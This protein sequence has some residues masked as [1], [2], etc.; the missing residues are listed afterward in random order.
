[1]E[2]LQV[3]ITGLG[4]GC[5]YGLIAL[6]FVLIYKA[7]EIVNFAQG[8]LLMMGAFFGVTYIGILGL[9]YWLGL[10]LTILSMAVFGYLLD[11]LIIRSMIGE[12][13]FSVII[14]TISIGF[15]L[16]SV[17]GAFWGNDILSLETPYSGKMAD[18]AGLVIAQDY[19]VVIAGT[20][21]LSLA[22]FLFFRFSSLGVAMQA[23][24]QNQLAAYYMGIPVK[25][26]FSL[27][28]AV[29]AMVASVAGVLM[30]PISLVSPSMGFIGIKA[31]AAAVIGGFGSLPGALLGGL[32]IGG[33]E[34]LAGT[35]LPLGFQEI[36]AYLIMFLVLTIRPQ[37]LFAQ[38]QQ[39]K[40]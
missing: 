35:Y 7:T 27:I 37:G 25:R 8:E 26:V 4:Q 15:I 36:T 9:P 13:Q 6:G 24:S 19:L 12:S 17:A 2:L 22:L 23:S 33:T 16:R 30:A 1:M 11:K 10:L 28:W 18:I 32:I 39:K 40:V 34:Q 20:I 38:I 14:L 31:F 5:L 3:L 29:S 21:I